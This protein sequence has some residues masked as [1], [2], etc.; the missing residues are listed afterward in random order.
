MQSHEHVVVS[1]TPLDDSQFGRGFAENGVT[2]FKLDGE[3]FLG[4][5]HFQETFEKGT[6]PHNPLR[7]FKSPSS[8]YMTYSMS[9]DT[10]PKS[11]YWH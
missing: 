10:F 8:P 2:A 11:R 1:S 7:A 3:R 4:S 6:A 9:I 5:K